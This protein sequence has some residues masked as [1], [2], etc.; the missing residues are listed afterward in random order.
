MKPS[1]TVFELSKI[2]KLSPSTVSRALKG[3]PDIAPFTKQRVLSLAEKLEYEPNVYAV[4]LRTS[5]SKEFGVILPSLTG[6]FYD[7]LIAT[8]EE[9]AR[10]EGFSLSI[11]ISS[12]D[13][14]IE[15]ENLKICR[16]RRF[17]GVFVSV[18]SKS[19]EFEAFRKFQEQDI[20]LIFIDKVP[21]DLKCNRVC[22]EDDKVAVMAAEYII[23]KNKRNVLSLFGDQHMSITAWREKAYRNA[24]ENSSC[25]IS[26]EHILDT[27]GATQA[28]LDAFSGSNK[29]DSIFCMSDEI[30][31]GVMKAVQI[32]KLDIPKDAG[33]ISI[34]NGVFPTYYNPE[35]TYI[36]TSG[37]DLG[38]LAFDQ[39]MNCI[40]GLN[41]FTAVSVQ[42]TL[43]ENGSL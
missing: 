34:S 25:N 8:V 28:V 13:P 31:I 29:P 40:N 4:G 37:H 17:A 21:F 26:I 43:V 39:M 24:F 33:I 7:S 35:I 36:K 41:D 32:L 30:L 18:T 27:N 14:Q 12:E 15:L 38:K 10:I 16:Q 5:N 3:H 20:P 22:F 1:T 19:T 2:L 42:P 6:Y 23:N 9:L 11:F